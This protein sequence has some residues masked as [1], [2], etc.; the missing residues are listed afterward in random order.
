[1]RTTLLLGCFRIKQCPVFFS[2]TDETL[3]DQIIEKKEVYISIL[4]EYQYSVDE[5]TIRLGK[6]QGIFLAKLTVTFDGKGSVITE[7]ETMH[8]SIDDPMT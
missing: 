6:Y 8:E 3:F 4:L 7:Y 5:K 1:L 2:Q